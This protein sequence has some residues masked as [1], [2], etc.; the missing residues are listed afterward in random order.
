M[1]HEQHV[2][3]KWHVFVN[4]SFLMSCPEPLMG[5]SKVGSFPV[6]SG[7]F[8]MI[9]QLFRCRNLSLNRDVSYI[10]G[11][12]GG[13][14]LRGHCYAPICPYTTICSYASPYIC[15]PLYPYTSL[16]S[17]YTIYSPCVV[18][19]LGASVT[20]Y[21]LVFWGASVHLSDVSVSLS[22][23]I[24]S[25]LLWSNQ[26]LS[27]IVGCFL[28]ELDVCYASCCFSFL[29]SVFIMSQASSTTAMTTTSPVTVGCSD[30]S[31]PLSMATMAPSVMVV[32]ATSGLHD[33]VLLQL[34]TSRH[35]GSVVGLPLCHSSNL[36]LRCLFRLMAIMPWVLCR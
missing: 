22:I 7:G 23:S 35:S 32:P 27:I 18:E 2:S 30:M 24:A 31:S 1:S 4:L 16:C 3:H 21:V 14:H 33:V 8:L 13:F 25:Q 34:Q 5:I 19:T 17:P 29:C 11:R 10:R 20:P 28:T 36:C 12:H 6:Q 26:L 9:F 15:I